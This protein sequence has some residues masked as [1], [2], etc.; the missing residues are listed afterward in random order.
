L[1]IY[2]HI[3]AERSRNHSRKVRPQDFFDVEH[4]VVGGIYADFFVTMDGNLFDLLTHRCGI[5]AR[6]G[7]RVLQGIK[8]LEEALTE[9]AS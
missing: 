7:C 8:G 3:I 4:A 6:C 2:C 1:D 9:I 5:S